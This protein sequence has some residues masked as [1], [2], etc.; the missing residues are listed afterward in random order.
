[1]NRMSLVVFLLLVATSLSF[2]QQAPVL[3]KNLRAGDN[4]EGMTVNPVT[5]KAYVVA[6]TSVAGKAVVVFDSGVLTKVI[7]IT[8]ESEYITA[9]SV[10]NRIYVA[11]KYGSLDAEGGDDSDDSEEGEETPE[12]QEGQVLVMG[13][14]TVIDGNSDS[15]IATYTFPDA[16]EPEGVAVDPSNGVVYVGAKAP[17]GE[18]AADDVCNPWAIPIYDVGEPGDVECWTSGSIYVFNGANVAA[19]PIKIIPVG[20][21][22]ESVVFIDGKVYVANEDDGTVTIASAV[23]PDGTGGQLLTDT[24]RPPTQPYSLGIAPYNLGVFFPYGPN[25]LGCPENKFEADK[26]AA[27]AGSVF[28][29]DDRSRVA[30][31]NGTAVDKMLTIPG[32]TVCELIPNSDGGGA[33]TANNI[34]FLQQGTCRLLYVVS[35]QNTVAILDPITMQLKQE[36]I[37]P[38]AKHLDAIGVDSGT[39]RVWLT[40]EDLMAVFVVQGACPAGRAATAHSQSVE[41][42]QDTARGIRLTGYSYSGKPLHFLVGSPMHGKLSGKAPNLIYTPDPGYY[43]SD[44]FPFRVNDGAIDGAEAIVDITINFV[45]PNLVIQAPLTRLADGRYQAM[46]KLTELSTST[47]FDVRLTTATLSGIPGT[48][49]PATVGNIAHDETGTVVLTFPASVGSS[50]MGT[51]AYYAGTYTGGTFRTYLKVV[52]P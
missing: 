34:G 20:D 18:A 36:I 3:L 45:P 4:P 32:A 24:P 48:P 28:I 21:D 49:L 19:G 52:L 23:Y 29:T 41:T 5:H 44:A 9:D 46:V 37:I 15:V 31:I 8:N 47:A 25:P 12:P 42:N 22:P 11:T 39:N 43:G 6:E 14:L 30:K 51:D 35:E 2:A 38:E 10:R 50:G 17:E 26:M 7:P 1:M 16:V 33:N 27:G 40:D 13:T